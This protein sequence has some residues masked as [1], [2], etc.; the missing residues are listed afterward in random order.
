MNARFTRL[1]VRMSPKA[2]VFTVGYPEIRDGSAVLVL[3]GVSVPVPLTASMQCIT[4]NAQTSDAFRLAEIGSVYS[5]AV[6]DVTHK[7]RTVSELFVR[8]PW[9]NDNAR[10][11]V[12]ALSN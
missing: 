10:L 6:K 11:F 3:P 4:A 7:V 1:A 9:K 2:K 5:I 8:N 12:E